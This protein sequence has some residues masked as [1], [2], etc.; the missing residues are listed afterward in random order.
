[1]K[2]TEIYRLEKTQAEID[3][4]DIDPQQ[5][6]PLFLDPHFLGKRTDRW[7]IEASLTLKCF[8]QKLV[9]LIRNDENEAAKKMFDFLHEPNSTCLGLSVGH[10]KGN[11][12]GSGD[13]ENIFESLMKSRAIQ[14]GLI[15]DIEDNIIFVDKFGK[16]K[17]SDMTTNI[18]TK[19]LIDYTERQCLLHNIQL[20]QNVMS[21]HY[22]SRETND[23]T[24]IATSRLVHNGKPL[25]LVPKAIVSFS[26]D[27][28]PQ[29][30]YSHFILNFLQN[31][32]LNINSILVH[33]RAS[34]K[35]YVTKSSIA[36]AN[37]YSKEFLRNFTL[38][39]PEVL[40]HFKNEIENKPLLNAN[41]SDLNLMQLAAILSNSLQNITSGN[42]DASK[43]HNSI[44]GILT[45]LF[46]PDFIN[47]T[48]E[49]EINQGR[50][51]I[52]I[53]FDNASKEGIFWRL[54]NIMNLPCG[55]I[56]VECKNYSVDIANPELDQLSGRF[57]VN[58]G[59]VGIL[60]CRSIANRDLFILRCRDTYT[61]G[62]GL[63]IPLQDSDILI[64]LDNIDENNRTFIDRYI[65]NIVR[66][67]TL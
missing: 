26:K 28:T 57:S 61:A 29:K 41:I 52:D 34:G 54:S 53:L 32:H 59:K 49:R 43:F 19:S 35:R 42:Q 50:K 11:G 10:P 51:R 64:L 60:I 36:E 8:F 7:S 63:I 9:D 17:L 44:L 2:L 40:A 25:L 38:N 39:H 30:Y 21:G 14:T 13:T 47:P 3:F 67:I 6:T 18:I 46:Y 27:Y 24:S 12:V 66:E 23:W 55:Y 31:E 65:S 20:T 22:W 4:V 1:M 56:F 33:R 45:L 62:N 37:P 5:D 16:D 48:K 58:T 15:Q